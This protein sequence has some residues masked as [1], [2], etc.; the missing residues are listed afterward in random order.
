M[1]L[2]AGV[3]ISSGAVPAFDSYLPEQLLSY[4]RNNTFLLTVGSLFVPAISSAMHEFEYLIK[5]NP[6]TKRKKTSDLKMANKKIGHLLNS[7][8]SI[9][10]EVSQSGEMKWA[11]ENSTFVPNT[12]ESARRLIKKIL[13]NKA[14][15][16][17][18]D[19]INEKEAINCKKIIN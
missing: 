14:N 11:N 2:S 4:L 15:P 3:A 19:M 8:S 12:A 17:L 10:W 6:F 5:N 1:A 13:E 7:L 18:I 16:E 9:Q